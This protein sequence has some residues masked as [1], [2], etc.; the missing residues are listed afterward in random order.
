VALTASQLAAGF[1]D[2]QLLARAVDTIAV[3]H[4]DIKPDNVIETCLWLG[5]LAA[6]ATGERAH[7]CGELGELIERLLV[8]WPARARA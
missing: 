3:K 6:L 8:Q 4:R 5:A 2:E 7:F 1:D